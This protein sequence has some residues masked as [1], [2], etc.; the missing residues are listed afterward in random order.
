MC[1]TPL[2]AS[3]S[4]V[5]TLAS[6]TRTSPRSSLEMASSLPSSVFTLWIDFKSALWTAAPAMTWY[7]ST[8]WSSLMFLGSSKRSKTD[9]GNLAKA[10]F[11]GANTVKGPLPDS[12]SVSLPALSAVT[13]VER[14]GVPAASS[15]M[16]LA[17]GAATASGNNTWSMMC[18]TPLLAST[19]AVVTFASPTRTSPW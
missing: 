7:S 14:S 8:S 19:S 9:F 10:S 3:T 5:V 17:T 6:P 1:T 13:R 11:E 12:A 15:T 4:A 2:L 16:F 18:T